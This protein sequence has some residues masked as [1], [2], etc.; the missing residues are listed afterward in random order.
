[1]ALKYQERVII[2]GAF[3]PEYCWYLNDSAKYKDIYGALYNWNTV[4][5]GKLCPVGWHVPSDEE[6]STLVTFLGGDS[7]AGSKLKGKGTIHWTSPNRDGDNSSGFTALPAGFYYDST[8]SY[9]ITDGKV[10]FVDKPGFFSSDGIEGVWWS[11]SSQDT[12]TAWER[13]IFSSTSQ[14][15]RRLRWNEDCLSVRCIKDN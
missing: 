14:V 9:Y 12:T 11:S 7:T 4:V 5:T 10:M 6:W 2:P 15:N 8:I 13:E 1:M 3:F